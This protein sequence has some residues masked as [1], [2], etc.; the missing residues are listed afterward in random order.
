MAAMIL[1]SKFWILDWFACGG[2]QSE[3][4]GGQ[5]RQHGSA[6]ASP[7]RDECGNERAGWPDRR[8]NRKIRRSGRMSANSRTRE[9]IRQGRT[10]A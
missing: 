5:Y 7:S 3:R 6:G 4:D 2:W 9:R 10:D 1:D 8:S